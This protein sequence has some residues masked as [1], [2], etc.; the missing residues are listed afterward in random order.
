MAKR[1]NLKKAGKLWFVS[2]TA[3]TLA[4]GIGLSFLDTFAG[5]D[6]TGQTYWLAPMA[7]VFMP[8][9]IIAVESVM[10]LAE[11][12]GLSRRLSPAYA[13]Y[14]GGGGRTSIPLH[15]TDVR[16]NRTY[17]QVFRSITGSI[18]APPSRQ[19]K[20]RPSAFKYRNQEQPV[21][22]VVFVSRESPFIIPEGYLLMFLQF[23][24]DRQQGSG[25]GRNKNTAFSR[26]YFTDEIEFCSF[27]EYYALMKLC[28]PVVYDRGQ[29]RSGYLMWSPKIALGRI[30]QV[31]PPTDP[32]Y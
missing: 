1:Y 23:A 4:T 28:T 17:S 29:G 18:F 26:P 9:A 16:G 8:S 6:F 3:G 2:S 21:E 5:Y 32:V 10:G 13:S 22:W 15:R 12:V 14:S 7:G 27:N 11:E 24:W 25:R 20:S 31:I 30:K 19:I